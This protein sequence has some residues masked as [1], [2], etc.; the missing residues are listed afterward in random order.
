MIKV[1]LGWAVLSAILG[2]ALIVVSSIVLR[3]TP[4]PIATLFRGL[5]IIG[6]SAVILASVYGPRNVIE[7]IGANLWGLIALGVLSAGSILSFY[8]ALKL[9]HDKASDEIVTAINYSSLVLVAA[10]NIMVGRE[11]FS[12]QTLI[13][14]SLIFVGLAILA[15]R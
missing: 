2:A 7:S 12:L 11:T 10:L 6:I 13:G 8:T 14:I 4:T 1:W 3:N 15:L 5:G 9:A